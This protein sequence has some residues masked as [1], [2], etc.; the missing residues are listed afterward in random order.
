MDTRIEEA[1]QIIENN[2]YHFSEKPVSDIQDGIIR[3][4]VDSLQDKHS[5]FLTSEEAKDFNDQLS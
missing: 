3:G 2:Y 4:V 5:E 1:Y